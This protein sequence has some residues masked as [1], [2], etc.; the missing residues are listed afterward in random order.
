MFIDVQMSWSE[1]MPN[2]LVVD[3]DEPFLKHISATLRK[4]KHTQVQAFATAAK[5]IECAKQKEFDVV[6][7][8]FKMKDMD[9]VSFLKQI[10]QLQPHAVRIMASMVCDRNSLY[11]AINEAGVHRYVEKPCHLDI[12]SKIVMETL[13]E[14]DAALA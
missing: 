8:D 14:R 2:V 7:S 11:G 4:I 13:R 1:S 6:I 12:L 5:A 9:G 10:R 3:E